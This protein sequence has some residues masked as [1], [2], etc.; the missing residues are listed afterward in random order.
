LPSGFGIEVE[1]G[2]ALLAAAEHQLNQGADLVKLYMDG[3]DRDVAPFTVSE[4][5]KL[6]DGVAARGAKVTAHS[7]QL[8]GAKVAVE[9]GVA[10]LEHGFQLD[11]DTVEL[12][13]TN[14]VSLVSTLAVL[15]SFKTFSSTTDQP[16]FASPSGRAGLAA[17][18]EWAQFSVQLAHRAGVHI[19]SGTDFGG[20]SLRANQLAWEV[21]CLVAAGLTPREALCAA[22]VNGGDL[23]DE[24]EAGRIREGG[25]ADFALVHG[26]PLSEP[27]AMWRVWR[28]S[29]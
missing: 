14:R 1:G 15:A 21:E 17:Q 26:D 7:G 24:P 12:M 13:V 4:V 10:A 6:V 27:A 23:L 29:W 9:A 5:K 3:P 11:E 16:R 2:D 20:G 28:V 25:P 22:T 18:R 19:A 8:A